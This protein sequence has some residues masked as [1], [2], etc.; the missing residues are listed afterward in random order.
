[1]LLLNGASVLVTELS[2]GALGVAFA[3][4]AACGVATG[5]LGFVTV[6]CGGTWLVDSLFSTFGL[7]AGAVPQSSADRTVA[8][9]HSAVRRRFSRFERPAPT[10]PCL[11][12]RGLVPDND[13]FVRCRFALKYPA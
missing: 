2:A 9:K 1:M 8:A 3:V 10:R 6:F 11:L 12:S 7:C 4:F 5:A 13:C